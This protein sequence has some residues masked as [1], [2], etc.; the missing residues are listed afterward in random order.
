M[1]NRRWL[2]ELRYRI[3]V[4]MVCI[5][6]D[7]PE[8]VAPAIRRCG[9]LFKFPKCG[10]PVMSRPIEIKRGSFELRNSSVSRRELNPTVVRELLGISI[11]TKDLPGIGASMRMGCAA[12]ARDKSF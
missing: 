4:I 10:L 6:T 5:A 12:S 1:I 7:F 2:G 8:P 3:D 11:P 9:I